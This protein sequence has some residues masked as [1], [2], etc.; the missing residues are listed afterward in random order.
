LWLSQLPCALARI[1]LQIAKQG[2]EQGTDLGVECLERLEGRQRKDRVAD[3]GTSRT[4]ARGIVGLEH[5]D[6]LLLVEVAVNEAAGG[7]PAGSGEKGKVG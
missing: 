7:G 6:S 1:A 2:R 5:G 3:F 4:C